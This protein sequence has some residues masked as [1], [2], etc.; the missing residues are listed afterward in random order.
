MR[1]VLLIV[2]AG[3]TVAVAG[4]FGSLGANAAPKTVTVAMHDPGCHWFQVGTSFRKTL[5]VSGPVSLLNYDEA[6]LKVAGPHGTKV[7]KMG[8]HLTL[9]A[10]TYHITMV[11]QASDDNHLKLVVR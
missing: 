10:G 1:K 8:G 4:V 7:D 2:I 3:T 9:T 6:A 5:A 11:G